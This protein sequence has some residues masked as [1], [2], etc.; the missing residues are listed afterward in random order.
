VEISGYV[1]LGIVTLLFLYLM[2]QLIRTRQDVVDSRVDDRFSADLRIL[3]TAG[4]GGSPARPAPDDGAPRAYLHDPRLRTG[5]P[6]M[7]RP[8]APAG[9]GSVPAAA[10]AGPG[11][12]ERRT[13]VSSPTRAPE[14]DRA[15]ARAAATRRRRGAARRRLVLTLVLLAVTAGAWTAVALAYAQPVG[16]VVPTALLLLVLVLGRRA[17]RA[18]RRVER[19]EAARARAAGGPEAAARNRSAPVAA[20]PAGRAPVPAPRVAATTAAPP[21]GVTPAAPGPREATTEIIPAVEGA[22]GS[23]GLRWHGV[24]TQ[25]DVP[26]ATDGRTD[27]PGA[28]GAERISR[29]GSWTPVPVPAPTYTLKPS[30][31]RVDAAP[32]VTDELSAGADRAA[33]D[34]GAPSAAPGR[35]VDLDEVLER[36][37]AAGE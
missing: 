21:P 30:A 19:A 33:T 9:R 6:S 7:N 1:V 5:V 16:A 28:P 18:A 15:A 20:A 26:E 3:A 27:A 13:V 11:A 36:R 8:P 12:G 34:P 29:E 24:P 2:P 32:L 4:T 31:P 25:P 23:S 10:P 37:R 22:P 17:A 35:G 14:Q